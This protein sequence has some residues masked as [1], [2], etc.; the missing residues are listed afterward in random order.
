MKIDWKR[1]E[2]YEVQTYASCLIT[3]IPTIIGVEGVAVAFKNS[4]GKWKL[5]DGRVCW[6]DPLYFAYLI[7]S[8]VYTEVL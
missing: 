8:M 5:G 1:I 3:V 6:F 4:S 7:P 2:E